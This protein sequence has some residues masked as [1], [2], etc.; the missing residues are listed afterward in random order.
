MERYEKRRVIYVATALVLLGGGFL[1]RNT[2]WQ[3]STSLHTLMELA[4]TLLAAFVGTMALVR[5]FSRGD[6]QFLYVGAGFLGTAMLDGFHAVVTSIY[7]QPYMPSDNPHLVPWSWIASRLFL[8]VLLFVSWL[9][10]FRHRDDVSFRPNTKMVMLGTALATITSFLF[11]AAVPLPSISIEGGLIS[12]PAELLPAIFFFM[13]LTGYLYKGKWRDDQF[14]H[15]LVLSLIVGLA[16]QSVYMPFS[17]QLYDTEFNLAHLLKK[18]SYILVL[19]GLLTSLYQ[20]YKDFRKEEEALIKANA[21]ARSLIEASLDPLVTISLEGKITD[22][23]KA[24]EKATGRSRAEL[25]GEDF[26]YYF[27]EPDKARAGYRQVFAEGFVTDYPLALCHSDG[28]VTDVLYNAS[29]YRDEA[30]KVLGVFAAA[31]D[32]TERKRAAATLT[33]LAAIVESTNDAI[34]GKTTDGIIT[35]WNKGAEKIYGY[36]ADEIIGKPITFLA[37][38]SRHA[39]IQGFLGKIRNGLTVANYESERIRKDGAV[40]QVALTLSPIRDALGNISGISTIARDITEKKRME[41]ALHQASVYNRS[42]IEASQDPLVTISAEGKITDVNRATE[43]A[44]GRSRAELTDT[45]FSDYFTEPDKARAGYRQV[46]ANGF[47]TDYP[48]VLRHSDGHVT[49]VLY[50][51][52]VYRDEAGAVLGVFAAAR[53]I[54]KRKKAEEV[55]RQ[56]EEALKEAQRIA[57]LGSWHLDVA[58][59]Q[60]VWSEELYKMYGFDPALPPPL[61]TESM[62]LFTPESW[63]RLSTA[64]A[65]TR[66]TG[67]PYELELETVQ[68][69]G[70]RGWMLARGE[71]VRDACGAVVG[72]RGVVMDITGRKQAEE[73]LRRSEHGLTEAQRIA[74]LGNW[75]LDLA[76]NV[77]TWSDEIYRIFEID[78]EKFGASYEAFLDAIHPADREL[79]N[80]A[81]SNSVANKVP[82][83]IVH[84]LLMKDGRVKYVNEKCETHYGEDG[85][86]LRSFGTVHDITE[87]KLDEE[88]LQRLNRELRAISNCNQALMRAEDEQALLEDI[89]RIVCEDAGYRMAW[90]G[91]TEHDEAKTIHPVAW[92]GFENGYLDQAKLTWADTARGRG[93]SGVAVRSGQSACLQNFGTDPEAAPWRA[94]ALQRGYRSCISMPLKDESANT[95]GIFTIYSSEPNAFTPNEI[96]LLEELAGDMS[97]GI[98]V[99][100]TR[101]KRRLAE[102]EIKTLNVDLEQRVAERTAQLEAANKE[103]EAFAYSVSHDLRTPLRAIDGFSHILLD[104][105]TDKLDDEGK[106]LLN[107]VRDNTSRMGQLI[108][109]ILKFSRT[110]RVELVF[111]VIDMEKLARDVF[112]ELLPDIGHLQLDIEAIPKAMGDNAMMRQVFVN[113]LSNAIKFSRSREQPRI[114]VGGSIKGDETVYY[115]QD[116]GAGFDM[117][118][119]GKLFGVFQR[120]HGV[121][122]FEGTGIGLAIVKRVITRHGGRVWAEG[123]VG[124]GA[125]I[126]F[127]LPTGEQAHG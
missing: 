42:L 90:A 118:Y 17:E 107:V 74:H 126:Y 65:Q 48:L 46:F 18:L 21:Y 94:A 29:V 16:T 63:E 44:T 92:A 12:R 103:L 40:I 15:W 13:A 58:T 14:E 66:E 80:N 45:D 75:E 38:S 70:G 125:T 67:I 19:I 10:W 110:G 37:P 108:D 101:I 120:L 86:P 112:D 26:S 53:D 72:V 122:E 99:L 111:S 114:R 56:S 73:Q 87:R 121:T 49:D 39:E 124:E 62:K 100:R 104:D 105:Y 1:L 51:A 96:R 2:E 76:S 83:D 115:V 88:A 82:Y 30:G 117:Q 113:L 102:A 31:R 60:I 9:L 71:L 27:T 95:F 22:V 77:L 28:H 4:A 25:I 79:V 35:S 61:W 59:N 119:A 85:K 57:H 23:N 68:K 41:Q 78:P 33:Q 64:L 47:V 20:T 93:P 54:T 106:R 24:T 91:Y 89:C 50:N 116:N 109:D 55:L 11:F 43:K 7:F 97:F 127:A 36:T 6:A 84:R 8:S 69:D 123:I 32:I 98:M 3:G 5:F 81:Y 52:S 34:I